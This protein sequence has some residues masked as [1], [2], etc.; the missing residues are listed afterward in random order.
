M[1]VI[2][3][4]ESFLQPIAGITAM[5]QQSL[6]GLLFEGLQTSSVDIILHCLRT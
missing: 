4:L 3:S 1:C 5:L 2:G 6:E